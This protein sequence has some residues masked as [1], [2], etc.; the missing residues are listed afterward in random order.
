MGNLPSAEQGTAPALL[1]EDGNAA[2][3]LRDY[4]ARRGLQ[5]R[6]QSLL[7]QAVLQHDAEA[8][9]RALPVA[10]SESTAPRDREGFSALHLAIACDFLEG[11]QILV[12]VRAAEGGQWCGGCWPCP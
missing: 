2:N 11:V 6:A 12:E 3:E 8:V 5:M 9:R 1:L 4:V 10:L 7:F